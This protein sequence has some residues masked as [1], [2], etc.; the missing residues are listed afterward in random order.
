MRVDEKEQV[1]AAKAR[2]P[3]RLNGEEY[4]KVTL[5]QAGRRCRAP[6]QYFNSAVDTSKKRE[7]EKKT[8]KKNA[9]RFQAHLKFMHASS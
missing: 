4:Q 1:E 6:H 5:D 9:R 7:R 2:P 8:K 3:A